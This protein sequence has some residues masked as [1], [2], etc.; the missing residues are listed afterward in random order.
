MNYSPVFIK[1]FRKNRDA[2]W[3]T[4]GHIECASEAYVLANNMWCTIVSLW[5]MSLSIDF[6]N[7]V[8][9]RRSFISVLCLIRPQYCDPCGI[10]PTGRLTPTSQLWLVG[11]RS[12]DRRWAIIEESQSASSD[13]NIAW[14]HSEI[15]LDPNNDLVLGGEVGGV[16]TGNDVMPPLPRKNVNQCF[17]CDWSVKSSQ[18]KLEVP[19]REPSPAS[20]QEGSRERETV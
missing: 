16:Q 7:N 14:D 2:L 6:R 19:I 17:S 4:F 5:I 18:I 8:T 15:T 9:W 12:R 1:T 10:P 3:R 13:K 11:W 20:V